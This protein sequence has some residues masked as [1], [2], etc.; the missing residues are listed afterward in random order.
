MGSFALGGERLRD[1][2]G[3]HEADPAP[4]SG[5]VQRYRSLEPDQGAEQSFNEAPVDK[6]AFGPSPS[7]GA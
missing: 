6:A 2:P 4:E 7:V 3:Q 1:V 5:P